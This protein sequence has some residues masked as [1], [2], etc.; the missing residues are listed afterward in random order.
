MEKHIRFSKITFILPLNMQM[1]SLFNIFE[2][3]IKVSIFN[4]FHDIL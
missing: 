4:Q 3:F 2:I 1:V